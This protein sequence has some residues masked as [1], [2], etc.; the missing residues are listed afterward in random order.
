MVQQIGPA[1]A[2]RAHRFQSPAIGP[3]W[4]ASAFGTKVA[5][6]IQMTVARRA[7][8]VT[9]STLG[10]LLMTMVWSQDFVEYNV[11]GQVSS[12]HPGSTVFPGVSVGSRVEGWFRVDCTALDSDPDPNVGR[13]WSSWMDFRLGLWPSPDWGWGCGGMTLDPTN[14]VRVVNG[15]AGVTDDWT[16]FQ[17]HPGGSGGEF[18]FTFHDSTGQAIDSDALPSTS[19]QFTGFTDTVLYYRTSSGAS[20]EYGLSLTIAPVPEPSVAVLGGIGLALLWAF[21]HGRRSG[22]GCGKTP[23][24]PPG[25]TET[26]R[27]VDVPCRSFVARVR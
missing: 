20:G 17:L 6:R 5:M 15:V 13:Y 22:I 18:R 24:E 23:A 25:S 27:G 7:V 1:N 2:K 16:I 21:G 12:V 14:V 3:A 19:I 10:L 9:I 4:L 11:S 8:V 26:R